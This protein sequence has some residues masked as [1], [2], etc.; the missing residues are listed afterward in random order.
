MK[1]S[2]TTYNGYAQSSLPA[3]QAFP[4]ALFP[5]KH[6][7][8]VIDNLHQ[9][10]QAVHTLQAAGYDAR[11]IHL[12]TSQQFIA[13]REHRLQQQ[14]HLSEA[15]VRFFASTDDDFPGD[16]YLY[17]A[18]R[19]PLLWGTILPPCYCYDTFL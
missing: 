7:Y 19:G 6:V 16:V 17:E 8:R 12:L 9:A 2:S 18:Q 15:L 14:S 10:E 5:S 13:A 1:T 11:H 4:P 3:Q